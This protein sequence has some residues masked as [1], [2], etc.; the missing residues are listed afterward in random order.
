MK[1]VLSNSLIPILLLTASVVSAQ[2]QQSSAPLTLGQ[3]VSAY[4]ERNLELQAERYRLERTAADAIAAR[5]RPNPGLS[6]TAENFKVSG[7][8]PISFN[9]LYEVGF[10]YSETIELGG[11]RKLRE[12]VAEATMSAAEE[13]FADSMRKIGRAHV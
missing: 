7:P 2:A 5:L 12:Q 9:Q 4:M 11:K 10:T 8:P 3:V 13:R 1:S 6:V